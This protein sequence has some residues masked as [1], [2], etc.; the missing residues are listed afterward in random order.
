MP[1]LL[2]NCAYVDILIEAFVPFL[3]GLITLKRLGMNS[4]PFEIDLY[5]V[6]MQWYEIGSHSGKAM[7][8]VSFFP[9]LSVFYR[10]LMVSS[11]LSR[12]SSKSH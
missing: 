6:Y 9:P 3:A 11:W 5:T 8:T 4:S 7:P 12:R 10:Q 1:R 2:I